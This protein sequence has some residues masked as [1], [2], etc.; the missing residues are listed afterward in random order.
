MVSVNP[1]YIPFLTMMEMSTKIYSFKT[2][3]FP[4]LTETEIPSLARFYIIIRGTQTTK[5]K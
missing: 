2:I 5:Q 1:I 4:K 3:L